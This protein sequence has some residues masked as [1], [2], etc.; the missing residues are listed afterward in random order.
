MASYSDSA[1]ADEDDGGGTSDNQDAEGEIDAEDV[2]ED[3]DE[4]FRA[5][6]RPPVQ[7]PTAARS[8]GRSVPG[9]A[10]RKLRGRSKATTI[11]TQSSSSSDEE[12]AIPLA[13]WLAASANG[14]RPGKRPGKTTNGH[15]AKKAKK[16]HH[17]GM[18]R[19]STNGM[20][21]T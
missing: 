10:G 11:D 2:D 12:D 17:N 13:S 7:S 21:I 14:G 18:Q 8:G 6:A 15:V 4:F 5:S 19:A 9:Q 16:L 1:H 20:R 3:G